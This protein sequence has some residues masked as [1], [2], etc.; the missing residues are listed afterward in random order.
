M[1]NSY[2][3]EVGVE[4]MP[5]HVVTPSI[6]Q[7]HKRVADYLKEERIAFDSIKEYATPRRMALLI[8]GLADKQPDIDESVKGQIGRASCRERV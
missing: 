2:L 8:N 3:L 4:E 1:A 5:A 6:K 7:L